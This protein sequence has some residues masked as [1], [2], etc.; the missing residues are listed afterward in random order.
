MGLTENGEDV[1]AVELLADGRLLVSTTAAFVVPGVSGDDEDVLA[2]TPT[3]L[4]ANTQ[5]TY[6]PIRFF[7]GGLYG[8]S[9]NN[10]FAI[11]LP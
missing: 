11:D 6:D 1:D 8:L 4:G 9:R 10:V 2:F 5:G 7:S 3:S